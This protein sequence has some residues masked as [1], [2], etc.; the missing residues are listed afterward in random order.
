MQLKSF[1]KLIVPV[2][3]LFVL[4]HSLEATTCAEMLRNRT[5]WCIA[6]AAVCYIT[7]VPAIFGIDKTLQT[8]RFPKDASRLEA[9]TTI[10]FGFPEEKIDEAHQIIDQ[11]YEAL[12]KMYPKMTMGR[13]DV[14][15]ILNTFNLNAVQEGYCQELIDLG[16]YR[17]AR[18]SSTLAYMLFPDQQ[19]DKYL[20]PAEVKI[21]QQK[22][23]EAEQAQIEEALRIRQQKDSIS[24][25][26]QGIQGTL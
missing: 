1:Y 21:A 12:G 16:N 23:L 6:E 4:A 11:F 10:V 5:K 19:A 25:V 20:R 24:K 3:P 26:V 9:A 22:Q 7:V 2:I 13:S 8:I 18:E 15:D 14:V 17:G